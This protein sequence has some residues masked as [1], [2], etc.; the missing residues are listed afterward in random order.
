MIH[1]ATLFGNFKHHIISHKFIFCCL[2]EKCLLPET[3]K[4]KLH[5][6]LPGATKRILAL[7]QQ[8]NDMRA[9]NHLKV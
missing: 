7:Q 1:I 6:Y 3:F 2:Y 5:V 4:Q 8:M 9:Q